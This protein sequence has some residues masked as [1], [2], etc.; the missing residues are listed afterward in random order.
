M[1][2]LPHSY[3]KGVQTYL[4][5]RNFSKSFSQRS[6]STICVSA[7][8]AAEPERMYSLTACCIYFFMQTS[9][10]APFMHTTNMVQHPSP[11]TLKPQVIC[12][13]K[14]RMCAG[15]IQLS[16][17]GK[18]ILAINCCSRIIHF[19]GHGLTLSALISHKHWKDYWDTDLAEQGISP[20][21]VCSESK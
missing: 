4:K 2:P 14:K 1:L 13:I 6:F 19:S 10:E 21:P 16:P 15:N 17:I 5:V 3:K 9:A 18:A 8:C 11:Q 20:C 7:S 12:K